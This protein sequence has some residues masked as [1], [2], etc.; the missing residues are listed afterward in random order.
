M[1]KRLLTATLGALLPITA[2]VN[3]PSL[4][5]DALGT[6]E[7]NI[8]SALPKVINNE[9]AHVNG[10]YL[11]K[12]AAKFADSPVAFAEKVNDIAQRLDIPSSWL[13]ALIDS[14]SGF[15]TTLKNRRGS[16]AVGLIQFMP[17]TYKR[18]GIS[19]PSFD[20]LDQLDYVEA[21]LQDHIDRRGKI[22]SFTDLKL[23]VLYPAA[24]GKNNEYVLYYDPSIAYRQNSG[25]DM[26]DNGEV[27]VADIEVKMQSSYPG[28]YDS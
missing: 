9:I 6:A 24:V 11:I 10:L 22:R 8:V 15:N 17:S 21:Y 28:A 12:K 27:T 7:E 25:L 1:K 19:D 13:M 3:A 16:G 18:L 2:A 26:D 14:E 23:C 20:I 5:Q 4:T